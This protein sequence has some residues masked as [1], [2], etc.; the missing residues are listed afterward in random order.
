MQKGTVWNHAYE[1]IIGCPGPV[2]SSM[3]YEENRT[4][5]SGFSQGTEKWSMWGA[6]YRS[7]QIPCVQQVDASPY[8]CLQGAVLYLIPNAQITESAYGLQFVDNRCYICPLDTFKF[9]LFSCQHLTGSEISHKHLDFQCLWKNEV[10]GTGS[11]F[12]HDSIWL[13][14]FEWNTGSDLS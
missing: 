10:L 2:S 14:L 1:M 8:H 5:P 6:S 13:D 9:F 3:H 4:F 11:T 12:P 7:F